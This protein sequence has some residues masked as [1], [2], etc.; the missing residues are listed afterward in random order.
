M[1][2]SSYLS[3]VVDSKLTRTEL[4]DLIV[5]ELTEDMEKKLEALRDERNA[6]EEPTLTVGDFANVA[7]R[8]VIVQDNNEY[9]DDGKK[10]DNLA[11]RFTLS[12][13]NMPKEW[14]LWNEK[15][16]E[17]NERISELQRQIYKINN[18]SKSI[19]NAITRQLLESTTEGKQLMRL[20]FETKASQRA[21]L[22][23]EGK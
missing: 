1:D 12:L 23:G 3:Q 6:L 11:V 19:R 13:K 5:E 15:T 22:L 2:I 17:L 10:L 14:Q 16:E 18:K 8:E 7:K 21:K 9:D 4:V 20:L